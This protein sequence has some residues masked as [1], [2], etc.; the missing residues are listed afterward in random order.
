MCICIH[1]LV[2]VWVCVCLYVCVHV[3]GRVFVSAFECVCVCAFECVCVYSVCHSPSQNDEEVQAVPG[4]SKVTLLPEDAQGHHL[5]DHLDGKERKDEVIKV[6]EQHQDRRD[7]HTHS[8]T[9]I[10]YGLVKPFLHNVFS[11]ATM[12]YITP[13]FTICIQSTTFLSTST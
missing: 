7:T 5:D 8:H 2:C 9:F 1:L 4:I 3:C 11:D 13:S 6:L 12:L 10:Q